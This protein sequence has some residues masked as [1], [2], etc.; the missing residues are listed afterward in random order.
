MTALQTCEPRR[1]R[2]IGVQPFREWRRA[3]GA[4]WTKF[5]RS[6]DHYLLRFPGLADF[7]VSEQGTEIAV[8]P[9]PGAPRR[10]LEHLYANQVLP[11]AL[12]RQRKL[13]LH[14][15]AIEVDGG[16]VAFVGVS[17]SGKSTL[18]ASFGTDGF[19]FLTDYGLRL[20][21]D[22]DGYVVVPHRPSI[23]LRNDAHKALV[24]AAATVAPRL[25]HAAKRRLLASDAVPFCPEPRPLRRVYFLGDGRADDA[26]IEI[27]TGREVIIGLVMH[28]FLLDI[29]TH[30]IVADHFDRLAALSAQP[31][32][33]RLDYPR[34]FHRLPGVRSA[35][36]AH[37]VRPR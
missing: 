4:V 7:H 21:E 22:D 32:F 16:A 8:Y 37:A 13:V 17:G 20:E 3:S 19:R 30:D 14:G 18:A 27:L 34:R 1:Q 5:Y 28:S 15:S 2:S 33:F 26:T 29:D 24:E 25:R 11:L 6:A 31:L 9:V 12:S 23:G 10:T 36:V 35:I